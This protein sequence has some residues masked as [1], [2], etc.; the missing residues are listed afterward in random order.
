MIKVLWAS[1]NVYSYSFDLGGGRGGK[2]LT[3]KSSSAEQVQPDKQVFS[4]RMPVGPLLKEIN[5]I[6]LLSPQLPSDLPNVFSIF[7][8]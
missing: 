8:F 4:W 3:V 1:A 5:M 2:L 6:L 7:C